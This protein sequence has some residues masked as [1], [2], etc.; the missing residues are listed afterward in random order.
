MIAQFKVGEIAI[1]QNARRFPHLNG[2]EVTVL[3]VGAIGFT[4][5]VPYVG[6]EVELMNP[7]TGRNFIAHPDQLRKKNPP[8]SAKSIMRE[9]ILKAMQPQE[10][11][12]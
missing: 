10:V 11:D 8:R 9:T 1:I 3:V 6:T 2:E 7:S 12:A 4:H 5:G